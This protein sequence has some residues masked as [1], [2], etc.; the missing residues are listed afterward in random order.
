MPTDESLIRLFCIVDDQLYSSEIVTL[1]I[2]FAL[3]G[4]RYRAFYRGVNQNDRMFFPQL[5]EL[6]QLQ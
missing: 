3:R 1:G 2:L 5:P 6:T 4:G